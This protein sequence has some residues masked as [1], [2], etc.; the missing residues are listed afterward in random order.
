MSGDDA[1]RGSERGSG[2]NPDGDLSARLKRLET[3]LDR[4]RETAPGRLDGF[5]RSSSGPSGV[6]LA[7]RMSAEFVAGIIAGGILGWVFDRALGTSPWGVIV[8]LML[9]FCAGI[10]NV[11]RA[12][13]SLGQPSESKPQNG[14]GEPPP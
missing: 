9:G 7:F 10:Y 2:P 11:M 14:T 3:Q 1:R 12:S 4:K 6:G 5:G 13:G 8:F